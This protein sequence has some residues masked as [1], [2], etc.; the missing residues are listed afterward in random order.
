MVETC[1]LIMGAK[2]AVRLCPFE[3]AQNILVCSHP[4]W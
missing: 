1:I 4:N 2:E 3:R